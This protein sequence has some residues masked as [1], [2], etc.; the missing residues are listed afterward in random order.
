MTD[1]PPQPTEQML[2]VA[3]HVRAEIE[4]A[5]AAGEP[6]TDHLIAVAISQGMFANVGQGGGIH[7]R[8]KPTKPH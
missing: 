5:L 4:R 6:V 3:A 8:P 2:K 7:P 1:E